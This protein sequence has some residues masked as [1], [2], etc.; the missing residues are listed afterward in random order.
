MATMVIKVTAGVLN[1]RSSPNGVDIGDIPKD[2]VFVVDEVHRSKI[3]KSSDWIP[4]FWQGSDGWINA[5]WVVEESLESEPEVNPDPDSSPESGEVI[6]IEDHFAI[7]DGLTAAYDKLDAYARRLEADS[8]V[9][10]EIRRVLAA[11]KFDD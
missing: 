7:V 9:L 10:M 11:Q 6:A 2:Q 8:K 4:V 1:H 5:R 3:G